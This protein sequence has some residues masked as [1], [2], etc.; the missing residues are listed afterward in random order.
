MVG[1]AAAVS[2]ERRLGGR[3]SPR[4]GRVAKEMTARSAEP[5]RAA[6]AGR[7]LERRRFRFRSLFS[8]PVTA[9]WPASRLSPAP[10][11][12]A[13]PARS[14]HARPRGS[15]LRRRRGSRSVLPPRPLASRRHGC[16]PFPAQHG[17]VL[18]GRGRRS[19]PAA[20]LRLLR[21]ARLA[22]LHGGRSQLYS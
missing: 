7:G 11:V 21:H 10:C 14:C 15:R 12:A 9:S 3:L 18:R 16:L 6:P 19:A 5:G 17:E 22:C 13:P 1:V 2:R 8:S 20:T 4:A